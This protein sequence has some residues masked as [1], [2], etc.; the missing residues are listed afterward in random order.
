MQQQQKKSL[1]TNYFKAGAG[2]SV[3]GSASKGNKLS[4]LSDED[5]NSEEEFQ[6]SS[7]PQRT[8]KQAPVKEETPKS[9]KKTTKGSNNSVTTTPA[10]TTTTSKKSKRDDPPWPELKRPVGRSSA[11]TPSV[12]GKRKREAAFTPEKT[13]AND[14]EEEEEEKAEPANRNLPRPQKEESKQGKQLF[15]D[16]V[17]EEDEHDSI[18]SFPEESSPA[19][20]RRS[21]SSKKDSPPW[22]EVHSPKKKKAKTE[23]VAAVTSASTPTNIPQKDTSAA[24]SPRKGKGNPTAYHYWANRGP[25]PNLGGKEIPQGK[26]NCLYGKVF[27]FTGVLDSLERDDAI[28]LVEHYAGKVVK[29]TAKSL[30]HIVI[31]TEPGFSKLQKL[32]DRKDVVRLDEDGLLDLIR[33]APEQKLSQAVLAKLSKS[34]KLSAPSTTPFQPSTSVSASTSTGVAPTRL[35]SPLVTA[36][37]SEERKKELKGALWADKHKPRATIE[38][39]GNPGVIKKLSDWLHNWD[40][41]QPVKGGKG[42]ATMEK[43]RPIRSRENG[44]NAVLLS[45]PPGIG[46]T[47]AAMLVVRECGYTPIEFNASDVRSKKLIQTTVAQSNDNRSIGEFFAGTEQK[48]TEGKKACIIMDEVDGMSSGD[49]GGMAEIISMI[50]TSKIPIICLCNDRDSPK[51][52]SLANHCLDLRFHRPTTLQI[53]KRVEHILQLEGMRVDPEALTRLIESVHGDVRQLLNLLQMWRVGAKNIGKEGLQ[54]RL[55]SIHK[56]V[57]LGPFDVIPKLLDAQQSATYSLSDKIDFYFVDYSLV[58]LLIFENYLHTRPKGAK[59]ISRD[60]K[61]EKA[62]EM[63]IISA[64]VD[65]IS[66][67]DLMTPLI[68]GEQHWSLA[69]AHG[70]ISTVRPAS[71]VEGSLMARPSFPQYFCPSLHFF[72]SSVDHKSTQN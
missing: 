34:A 54:E 24:A 68:M 62:V 27:L 67:G 42:K 7:A 8:K 23:A 12:R 43:G 64:A 49:R 39:I 14:I 25:P 60:Q 37:F 6:H 69:P 70:V 66:D 35:P 1:I 55:Q 4:V 18:E 5:P 11:A 9:K 10:A 41:P 65:S 47:S 44:Y 40:I 53:Q 46:K 56:N 30:T 17:E 72:F 26:P 71:L 33:T 63:D 51:V 59:G 48:N 21:S 22:K 32:E 16:L 29:T 58:P 2:K 61:V 57:Q 45:G 19:P 31:G 50:K 20:T 38:L 15:M 3:G 13:T 28:R 52:R 36:N